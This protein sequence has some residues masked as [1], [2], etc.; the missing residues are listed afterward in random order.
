M[1]EGVFAG[2]SVAAATGVAAAT[3]GAAS[4]G[5]RWREPLARPFSRLLG[6]PVSAIQVA[7]L[8]T[9]PGL[10]LVV[11]AVAPRDDIPRLGL[12][13]LAAAVLLA[14]RRV[15]W[16]TLALIAATGILLRLSLVSGG[17]SDVLAVTRSAVE[18]MQAGLDPWGV[19]YATSVPAGA[20]FPYGPLALLWYAP[21]PGDLRVVEFVVG[22][23][24]LVALAAR[25]KALG[26]AVYALAPAIAGSAS[27]GSNDTSAGL[28]LLLA[29]LAARRSPLLGGAL[30]AA[31][32]S[33]KLYAAAWLP[34][35]VLFAGWPALLAFAVASAICWGPAVLVVG[36]APILESLRLAATM[37]GESASSFAVIV[38][39]VLGRRVAHELFEGLRWVAAGVA[40]L[41]ALPWARTWGGFLAGGLLVFGAYLYVG[42]WSSVSYLAAVAPI[43]CWELDD[44]VGATGRR[45]SMVAE[46]EH[47]VFASAA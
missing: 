5:N 14:R 39:A 13:A 3:R 36:I 15:G 46:P 31:A 26:L 6:R 27:D 28:I 33:F 8:V 21:F 22:T 10:L 7:W 45:A 38:E 47:E 18:R 29:L 32:V 17:G 34:G 1:R 2:G 30:L 25:G 4:L 40:A 12:L 37:H 19:T 20:P 9:T 11:P 35:L 16:G 24:V 44:L 43:L 23:G 41:V 42:Y